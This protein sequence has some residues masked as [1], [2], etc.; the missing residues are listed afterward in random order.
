MTSVSSVL[1]LLEYTG[2]SV[3][4]AVEAASLHPATVLGLEDRKGGL[5]LGREADLVMLRP[6]S[7]EI[8]STWVRGQKVFS[9]EAGQSGVAP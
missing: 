4:E 1:R 2:C 7:L 9:S 8:L 3:A 5:G 6:G